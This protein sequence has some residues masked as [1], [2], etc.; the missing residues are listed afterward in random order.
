LHYNLK[1]PYTVCSCG[2]V[3]TYSVNEHHAAGFSPTLPRV[4]IV[5]DYV[6][7]FRSSV[8]DCRFEPIMF[9]V[10]VRVLCDVVAW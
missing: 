8:N 2:H 1:K 10:H 5:N 3:E 6:R 4:P 7:P 9:I